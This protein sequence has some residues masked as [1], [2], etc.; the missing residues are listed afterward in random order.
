MKIS[1]NTLNI[2]PSVLSSDSKLTS[3]NNNPLQY[4]PI[5]LFGST[6]A[7]SGLAIAWKLS[8]PLFGVPLVVGNVIGI[9]GNQ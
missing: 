1:K 4:Q 9:F 7:L 3:S 2:H 5:G 8:V 6:V